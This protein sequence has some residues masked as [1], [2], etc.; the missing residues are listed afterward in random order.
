MDGSTRGGEVGQ[1]A[2]GGHQR[3]A[4]GAPARPRRRALRGSS[5]RSSSRRC[6]C[7][8]ACRWIDGGRG[9]E[10]LLVCPV[11]NIV[12]TIHKSL[13]T[14]AVDTRGEEDV[15]CARDLN[16]GVQGNHSRES[17]QPDESWIVLM[18]SSH[19]LQRGALV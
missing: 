18:L 6:P 1:R 3:S 14:E 5:L 2:L 10:A 8:C 16:Q 15:A 17:E 13:S 11:H 12:P 19:V 4:R 9:W 7:G